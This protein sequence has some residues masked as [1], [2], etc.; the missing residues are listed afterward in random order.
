[1]SLRT[2]NRNFKGRSGTP[3]AHVYLVS[4]ETAAAAAEQGKTV[5]PRNVKFKP[6]FRMPKKAEIP[7]SLILT[8]PANRSKTVTIV[9]GPNIRPLPAFPPL[10]NQDQGPVLIKL[11]DNVTTDDIMPAGA[12][13]LPLR[14]NIPAIAEHVF[15]S[16]DV[17]FAKR[18]QSLKGGYVVGGENYGQG[19][20]RE[21]A[22]LAPRYLGVRA[23]LAKSF[24]RIHMANLINF[25]ILPLTFAD[26]SQ[27]QSLEPGQELAFPE[28]SARLSEGRSIQVKNTVTGAT[29]EMRCDLSE[30]QR[31]I[32][33]A[34][35]M[36][37]WLKKSLS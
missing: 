30:R 7:D 1:V 33:A 29:W 36:L 13:I 28:L 9:R 5:D 6:V 11:G 4:P 8:P 17:G 15:S 14:S 35:G 26:P 21:H 12:K 18:A 19:S 31:E 32:L 20:S 34:G 22:A 10:P 2:F 27:Y 23:V 24:A 25:G 37:N 3:D 16:V